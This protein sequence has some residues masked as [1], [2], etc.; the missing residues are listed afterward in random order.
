MTIVTIEKG[1]HL[2]MV[3]ESVSEV[4]SKNPAWDSRWLI[5]G[6]TPEGAAVSTYVG[7]K[8]MMQQ[9]GR[10]GMES[11]Q[12]LVSGAYAF[13][14]TAE[15]YLNIIRHGGRTKTSPVEVVVEAPTPNEHP[16]D[17]PV[18]GEEADRAEALREAKRKRIAEDIF[19]AFSMADSMVATA[20]ANREVPYTAESMRSV[21]ALAATLHISYK[22][23]R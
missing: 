12:Q 17:A 16:F 10:I 1:Q 8:A 22:E 2:K 19:W 13:E 15:G 21:V 7:N 9:L 3:V 23:A 20:L 11:A 5:K 4:E 18:E 14:R 6:K